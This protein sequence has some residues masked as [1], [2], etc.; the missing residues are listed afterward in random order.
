MSAAFG[1]SQIGQIATT[2]TD[3]ARA[4]A[5]YRDSLGLPF[6]FEVPNMAFFDCGGIRLMLTSA[7]RPGESFSSTLRLMGY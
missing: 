7:E 3:L 4:I 6:L 2:V 5:F 1:L